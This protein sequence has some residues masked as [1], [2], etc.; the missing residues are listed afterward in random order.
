MTKNRK[1][2]PKQPF[3]TTMKALLAQ[4][5]FNAFNIVF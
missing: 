5:F 2:E 1:Q 3:K 4:S